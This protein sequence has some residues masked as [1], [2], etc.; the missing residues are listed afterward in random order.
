M[1]MNAPDHPTTWNPTFAE[2]PDLEPAEDLIDAA[3]RLLDGTQPGVLTTVDAEGR[4]HARWMATMTFGDF[5]RLYT[6][7]SP[8]ARKLEHIVACPWVGWMFS[9]HD[10]TLV[11]TLAG[12]AHVLM[13][14]HSIKRIWKMIEDKSH[15]YFLDNFNERPGFT[16]IQTDVEDIECLVPQS[17]LCQRLDLATFSRDTRGDARSGRKVGEG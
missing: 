7:T 8:H 14:P 3:R 1:M 6:L 10:L 15:A 5:P 4:P 17:G 13:D 11:L 16:V 12:R 2:T 9:N